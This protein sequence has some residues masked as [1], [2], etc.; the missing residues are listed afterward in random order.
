LFWY[1]FTQNG[2]DHLDISDTLR[3]LTKTVTIMQ[4]RRQY[5]ESP[6]VFNYKEERTKL[7]LSFLFAL[8]EEKVRVTVMI[9]TNVM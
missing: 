7:K 3:K 9:I 8:K 6:K 5:I 1:I 2:V 4:D